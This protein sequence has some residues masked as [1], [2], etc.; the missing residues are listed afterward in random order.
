MPLQHV[1]VVKEESAWLAVLA[2]SEAIAQNKLGVASGVSQAMGDIYTEP[3]LKH[4]QQECHAALSFQ[5]WQLPEPYT[6]PSPQSN[7]KMTFLLR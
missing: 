1:L 6:V 3:C 4:L 5:V 7:L 2:E